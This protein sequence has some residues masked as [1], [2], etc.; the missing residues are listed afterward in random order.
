MR[1]IRISFG[2]IAV[3]GLL[4]DTP[5]ANLIWD[6]LPIEGEARRWGDE[7]YFAIPVT[8]EVDDTA[9]EI[10]QEGDLGYW[11]VGKAFCIFF[12]PTPASC[13]RE[14]RAASAVNVVGKVLGD[15]S[16]LHMV[17]DG[18]KVNIIKEDK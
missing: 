3:I 15:L 9:R 5:T 11:P 17:K 8:A 14:I 2:E 7:I 13:G 6:I 18:E 1:K 10:L 12:G 4:N 16:P